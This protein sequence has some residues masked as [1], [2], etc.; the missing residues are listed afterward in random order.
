MVFY[1]AWSAHHLAKSDS[2]LCEKA[3]GINLFDNFYKR[4]DISHAVNVLSVP[5]GV[6]FLLDTI[7]HTAK[8]N[9]TAN[10]ANTHIC[11][12]NDAIFKEILL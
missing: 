12:L 5:N 6:L 9:V 8:N 10:D 4:I 2:K 3:R 7:Y 1:A 11:A